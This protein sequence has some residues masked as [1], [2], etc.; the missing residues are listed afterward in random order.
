MATHIIKRMREDRI[1]AYKAKPSDLIE[2][3]NGETSF[4]RS[5]KGRPLLELLQ[6]AED[7]MAENKK[8]GKVLVRFTNDYLLIANEGRPLTD[9]G[10]GAICNLHRSPKRSDIYVG[11]KGLGFKSILNWTDSPAIYSSEFN[12]FWDRKKSKKL[13]ID[14]EIFLKD[15]IDFKSEQI[16]LLRLPFETDPDKEVKSL[17]EQGFATVI[18]IPYKGYAKKEIKNN[19]NQL[20]IHCFA[21][22]KYIRELR[23]EGIINRT[24]IIERSK[25]DDYI[26]VII[27]C[28]EEYKSYKVFEKKIDI[29]PN[30]DNAGNRTEV[31]IAL[32]DQPIKNT[33]VYNFF[34]TREMNPLPFPIHG[35]FLLH[36][37][38][39]NIR[40][41]D[42]SYHDHLIKSIALLFKDK[43]LKYLS[44][45]NS[46]D[47]LMYLIPRSRDIDSF[48]HIERQLWIEYESVIK[49]TAFLPKICKEGFIKPRN[50][51]LW[52]YNL[53]NLVLKQTDR[54]DNGYIL[55]PKWQ[56]KNDEINILEEFYGA[57]EL[58]FDGYI[59][60]LGLL[61]VKS[62]DITVNILDLVLEL[63]D[64]A[65]YWD[66]KSLE[67]CIN[68][69]SLWW[70]KDGKNYSFNNL[71]G[72]RYIFLTEPKWDLPNWMNLNIV[73]EDFLNILNNKDKSNN[74]TLL[75]KLKSIKF[76][77]DFLKKP[78]N[79]SI[80]ELLLS[81][82]EQIKEN[83]WWNKYGLNLLKVLIQLLK[84]HYAS[85][86]NSIPWGKKPS[87]NIRSR[88]SCLLKLPTK[89][90]DWM[91]PWKVYAGLD[92]GGHPKLEKYFMNH[93]DRG[94]LLLPQ[95]WLESIQKDF[96]MKNFL[97]Y[98]GVSWYPK[99]LPIENYYEID[100]C[101]QNQLNN[102]KELSNPFKE[103]ALSNDEWQLYLNYL[104]RNLY[105]YR[106]FTMRA[107]WCIDGFPE[108]LSFISDSSSIETAKVLWENIYDKY[109]MILLRQPKS[110]KG[111][112]SPPQAHSTSIYSN[113]KLLTVA[114]W[115]IKKR[116][117]IQTNSKPL[118]MN[119]IYYNPED[120]FLETSISSRWNRLVP[121]VNVPDI[122][123]SKERREFEIFCLEIGIND[124]MEKISFKTWETWLKRLSVVLSNM[125]DNNYIASLSSLVYK[126]FFKIISNAEQSG[127]HD[128]SNIKVPAWISED[129]IEFIN[130]SEVYYYD[131]AFFDNVRA[132]I[133]QKGIPLFI[134][135][136]N[137]CR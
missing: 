41:D 64:N 71:P 61:D 72:H 124:D 52:S 78:D 46:P 128:W 83:K 97:K 81:Y 121:I 11:N 129:K 58:S 110:G 37:G 126:K 18:K 103:S 80:V 99:I 33:Y 137:D 89:S 63:W 26:N 132:K 84:S 30:D 13:I 102:I 6:N 29:K 28:G 1:K 2:H 57:E 66:K 25:T 136:L 112:Q 5:Y 8:E 105:D 87:E 116:P 114:E 82:I 91:A 31:A 75:N 135:E 120:T 77:N 48:K 27:T 42:K 101:F 130:S 76:F 32:P 47:I 59:V 56:D 67:V 60:F 118:L 100:E 70:L 24:Y 113:E 65:S 74:D 92:F 68:K 53:G 4:M 14:N 44:Q 10:L 111:S 86:N 15:I 45:K 125:Y 21:F 20:D 109:N 123:D 115:Q 79:N 40:E 127:L 131:D 19:I 95:R 43:V 93:S 107:N 22:L 85:V 39:E 106:K 38:R 17:L 108:S 133:I 94:I 23:I 51:K 98:I 62:Y 55:P 69:L 50:V 12:I 122:E 7:A 119:N 35:T 49:N 88:L 134:L 96:D 3:Y 36:E 104:D 9:K 117:W 34:K 54:I 90:K 16:P 73:H